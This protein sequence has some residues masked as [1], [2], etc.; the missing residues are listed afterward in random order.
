MLMRAPNGCLSL[1][2]AFRYQ[3]SEK[4]YSNVFKRDQKW[5][6]KGDHLR[7]LPQLCN[8]WSAMGRVVLPFVFR[9]HTGA[10]SSCIRIWIGSI[11]ERIRMKETLIFNCI[12]LWKGCNFLSL[13][14]LRLAPASSMISLWF[15]LHGFDACQFIVW[16]FS[17]LDLLPTI[18]LAWGLP[19]A[20]LIKK[21]VATSLALPRHGY[22][23]LPGPRRGPPKPYE[24]H[25]HF[26][27]REQTERKSGSVG[28][29]G[30]TQVPS[31][32][33]YPWSKMVQAIQWIH[34]LRPY[35]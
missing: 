9:N 35:R 31:S 33:K 11:I 13:A 15:S 16:A 1:V 4:N 2:K 27:S 12:L 20:T 21:G 7:L 19:A 18:K 26:I 28:C 8:P 23:H 30:H 14:S 25:T 29:V 3:T 5:Q 17:F 34:T 10:Y 22:M 6:G 32:S 24:I